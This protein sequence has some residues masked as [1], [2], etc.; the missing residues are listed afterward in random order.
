MN[1]KETFRS[2]K[3][4]KNEKGKIENEERGKRKIMSMIRNDVFRVKM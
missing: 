3:F 1:E 2:F 4:K